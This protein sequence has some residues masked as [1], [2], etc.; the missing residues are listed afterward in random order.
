M[1]RPT[2]NAITQNAL[3][4]L[5]KN[6][7]SLNQSLERLASGR[8]INRGSDDPAGVI[9]AEQLDAAIEA[10]EAESQVL[11]RQNAQ[12]RIADGHTA[13]LADMFTSLKGELVA[14]ANRTGLSEG[15]LAV[16]QAQIDSIVGS[17]QRFA[18]GASEAVAALGLPDGGGQE[19]ADT[20]QAAAASV[21][22]LTS[23]G[24]K[25]LSS[26]DVEAALQTLDEALKAV[27]ETR[28][29]IGA[30]AKYDIESR[31]A[32]NEL[33]GENLIAAR[34]RI[35]DTDYAVETSNLVRARVLTEAST[36]V[37]GII[38]QNNRRV[39]DLLR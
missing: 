35:V 20:L 27:Q 25:S 12:A 26:G 38:Q 6:Q 17:I 7:S 18:G 3:S 36:R 10:L 4:G 31:L 15:E 23:G 22:A 16:H 21:G 34:S 14:A 33:T 1:I 37:L 32:A 39:L 19:L 8:R 24:A 13:Q 2:N 5:R 9:S 28:G 11:D 29:S 30:F